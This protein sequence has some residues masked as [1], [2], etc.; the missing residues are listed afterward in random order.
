MAQTLGSL[1]LGLSLLMAS[2][3]GAENQG[4]TTTSPEVEAPT[5]PFAAVGEDALREQI[6]AALARARAGEKRVLLEF[7]ADWCQDCREV[8]RVAS[9]GPAAEVLGRDYEVVYVEVG[10]FDRHVELIE[11]YRI[12]RI[13]TLVVLDARGERVAQTTLEPLSNHRPLSSEALAGWLRQ[14][15]DHWQNTPVE[16]REDDPPVFPPEIVE[17]PSN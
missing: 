10:R 12:E 8:V 7:V 11:R 1:G 13:A 2:C 14:P 5:D 6:Q 15:V 4:A 3:D 9:A 16:P 17:E